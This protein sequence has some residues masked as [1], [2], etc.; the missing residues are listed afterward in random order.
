M[1]LTGDTAYTDRRKNQGGNKMKRKILAF[2]LAL[3]LGLGLFPT[4]ALAAESDFVIENGVLTDYRGPGG[5]VVI[6]S[7]V[8]AI[9][10]KAFY[11]CRKLTGVTIPEGVTS[12]GESAFYECENLASVSF[13][14]SLRSIG[15]I[16]FSFTGLKTV[17]L[18]KGL[19]SLGGG[20]FFY[21]EDLTDV[22]IGR[23]A[24]SSSSFGGCPNLTSVTL[25]EELETLPD[26]GLCGVL[27]PDF[28]ITYYEDM[29]MTY[30]A[31]TKYTGTA[32]HVEIP[33]GVEVILNEAFENCTNLTSVTL[34]ES[35]IK[36]EGQGAFGGCTSLEELV[37]PDSVTEIDWEV[38]WDSSIRRLYLPDHLMDA[39]IHLPVTCAKIGQDDIVSS[40]CLIRDGSLVKYVGSGGRVV[41]PDGVTSIAGD[42]FLEDTT[43]TE[44]VISKGVK[45]ISDSAFSG[46]TGLAKVTIPDGVVSIGGF[47][48][49]GCTNLTEVII[50]DSVVSIGDLAFR[51]CSDL[52]RI[53]LPSSTKLGINVFPEGVIP[54]LV[55]HAFKVE[56]GVLKGYRGPGGDVVIPDTVTDIPQN[57]LDCYDNIRRLTFPSTMVKLRWGITTFRTLKEV[58]IPASVTDLGGDHTPPFADGG[59]IDRRLPGL[60]VHGAA[61]SYAETWA[62]RVGYTFVA[63]QPWD[64]APEAM[65][66][67]FT[68]ENG[69]LK[70]YSGPG[71]DVVVPN[72]VKE[73][74]EGVFDNLG[75]LDRLTL[76]AGIKRV[77]ISNPYVK[78]ITMGSGVENLSLNCAAL[79]ELVIPDGVT[80][81]PGLTCP[82]LRKLTFPKDNWVFKGI[83]RGEL[84]WMLNG[85]PGLNEIVNCPNEY[86][87]DLIAA[88]ATLRDNWEDPQATAVPQSDRIIELSNEITAGLTTDYD[89]A[90]AI[91]Q[92]VVDHIKY[93]D[94]YYYEGLKDYSDVPFDPADVLDTGKA[95]CAGFARLTQALM[96][97]Q[98][99]PCLYVLG[100][101]TGGYHAWNLALVDGEYLWIDNTW[102]MKYFG[103][104]I[105]AFSTEHR[106]DGAAYFNNVNGPGTLVD[107]KKIA[108]D[109]TVGVSDWAKAE[110][111]GAIEDGL[112]P[113]DLQEN[114]TGDI[115]R[116]DFCRVMV[117]LV[118][119]HNKKKIDQ[120]LAGRG[121]TAANVFTDTD[122][123]DVGAAYALGIVKGTSPTT[124]N[125]NGSITRQEAATMLART[126]KV[127]GLSAGT[128]ENFVDAWS[129]PNW[130]K[131]GIAFV[132]GLTDRSG[133]NKVMGGTGYGYFSPL[134]T[135]TREQSFVTALRIFRCAP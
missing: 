59:S 23:V 60:T 24:E 43:V 26:L 54:T 32:S 104:G 121:L 88:N 120:Y 12:I 7:G 64:V 78:Y 109:N 98:N 62:K 81:R 49:W 57:V 41:I 107:T 29:A 14:E 36:L 86:M 100:S 124:F 5:N 131:D 9:G 127:L 77:K 94:D 45:T 125:P 16:A 47:A 130:A 70:E 11:Y 101:S 53:E 97:A 106:A 92:W 39:D 33:N 30:V 115:T 95:V 66:H 96:V 44:V 116:L 111:V 67:K 108:K 4:T 85:C 105:Y 114:Y 93:D 74:E 132:S 102:G 46:C 34:P 117:R 71:G 58:V 83:S 8:T 119:R 122:H 42:A 103:M 56:N 18:P 31:L 65:E 123:A 82:S 1:K 2:V 51:D 87:D 50:P 22:T 84:V 133:G 37:I 79:R 73:L 10:E 91:S 112:V 134:N 20:A 76:P 75:T 99:I 13:P 118:E 89:K 69:V 19:E 126:A 55:G 6:P 110:V 128:A 38:F 68:I 3:C 63:D 15:Q 129:F 35:L 21:C 25:L 135:F 28:E 80:S 61:G 17:V 52:A 48:F 72:S 40:G 113:V 90:K 27:Y